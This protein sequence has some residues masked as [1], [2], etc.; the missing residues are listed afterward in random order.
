MSK[1]YTVITGA[2]AGIGAASARAFAARGHSLILAARRTDRLE[3][4]RTE[5]CA[6]HADIDIIV[7]TV[8]LSAA[9]NVL[10]F[11]E[12]VHTLP[13]RTWINNA[14]F[15]D[16]G[17]V[18]AQDLDKIRPMLHLNIE[19]LTIL[20][21]LFVRDFADVEGTQ[22]INI[23]SVGGYLIVPNVVTY[24]AT[25]FYVSA[26]TEGLPTEQSCA[27][28]S[29]HPPPHRPSLAPLRTTIP[30]MTTT[31]PS[32][33]TIRVP[34]WQTSCSRSMTVT[35]RSASSTVRRSPSVS[36]PRSIPMQGTLHA[37]KRCNATHTI[38]KN[39][40]R[41]SLQFPKSQLS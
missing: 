33:P 30:P 17:Q 32:A 34:R 27:S 13:L 36:P 11:Y 37:I 5:L 22:L 29:S 6:A 16:Y 4:L 38:R 31:S 25:K 3:A 7:K 28:K 39:P 23:S 9:E 15:G 18:A 40:P 19:A 8:D 41:H 20:S 12:E 10:R 24:C 1:H 2:S 14:G 21:M 35:K 26:F